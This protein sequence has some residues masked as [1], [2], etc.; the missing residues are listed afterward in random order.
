[1]N[2]SEVIPQF[3]FTEVSCWARMMRTLHALPAVIINMVVDVFINMLRIMASTL[4][5]HETASRYAVRTPT[6]RCKDTLRSNRSVNDVWSF[7]VL[8]TMFGPF[9][10]AEKPD[11]TFDAKFGP[12][13]Y[14]H[15]AIDLM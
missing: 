13:W 14:C 6:R 1:M 7:S 10:I 4:H 11:S 8:S 5:L 15:V 3:L 2:S 12:L 9:Q